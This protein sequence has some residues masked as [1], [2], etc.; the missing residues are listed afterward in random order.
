M[1]SLDCHDA[2]VIESYQRIQEKLALP[3]SE[4]DPADID[5]FIHQEKE[6][7]KDCDVDLRDAKRR[8]NSCKPKAKPRKNKQD[9]DEDSDSDK[10]G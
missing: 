2:D 8:I 5:E 3:A 9:P 4:I 10:S 1:K 6:A 7:L